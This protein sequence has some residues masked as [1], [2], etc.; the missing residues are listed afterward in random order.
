MNAAS[1]KAALLVCA[2]ACG[3]CG[4]DSTP[5][6][7]TPPAALNVA[8]TWDG[9]YSSAQLGF[10]SATLSL[11]QSGTAVS[12][13]WSTRPSAGGGNGVGSGTVSGTNDL[14]GNS[15]TFVLTMSPSDPRTCPFRSTM[16]V[17]IAQRQMT[18]SWVTTNCTVTANGGLILTKL[19]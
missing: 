8:G 13:T 9:T 7:P 6:A 3:A 5:A 15:G 17:F 4:S 12:G 11:S 16:T 1:G 18:G 14:T 2:M 19:F 10:G